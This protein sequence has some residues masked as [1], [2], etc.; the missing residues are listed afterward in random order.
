MA[1]GLLGQPVVL[2]VDLDAFAVRGEQIEQ[3]VVVGDADPVAVDQDSGDRPGDQFTEQLGQVR[4]QRRLAPAEHQ[5]VD[6][7]VLPG[8]PLVDVGQHV[9]GRYHVAQIG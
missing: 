2:E 8:Q 3:R 9:G 6:A 7:A 1:V 5:D 4:V